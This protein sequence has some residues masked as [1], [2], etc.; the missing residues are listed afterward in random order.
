MKNK[1]VSKPLYKT[2]LDIVLICLAILLLIAA[3]TIP[4][5][6]EAQPIISLGEP[7]AILVID[8][9]LYLPLRFTAESIGYALDYDGERSLISFF[10]ENDNVSLSMRIDKPE[11]MKNGAV[12][13]LQREVVQHTNSRIYMLLEDFSKMLDCEYTWYQNSHTVVIKR[14]DFFVVLRTHINR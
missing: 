3:F 8:D 9:H 6:F 7:L 5:E 2:H 11:Y 14:A 1:S 13:Q 12:F 10:A 4:R